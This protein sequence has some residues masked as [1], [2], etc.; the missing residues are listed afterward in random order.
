MC[1]STSHKTIDVL[2]NCVNYVQ[3][4]DKRMQIAVSIFA[5]LKKYI[6]YILNDS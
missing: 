2:K 1:I 4:K 3:W 5:S 6:Y